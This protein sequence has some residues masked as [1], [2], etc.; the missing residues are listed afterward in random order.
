METVHLFVNKRLYLKKQIS[1]WLLLSASLLPV[2]GRLWSTSQHPERN[3]LDLSNVEDTVKQL[4]EA[5]NDPRETVAPKL[6]R[7]GTQGGI[8]F[9]AE[10]ETEAVNLPPH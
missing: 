6:Y 1:F 10:E 3:Y 2:Y 4:S 7:Y 5:C 9:M 8:A